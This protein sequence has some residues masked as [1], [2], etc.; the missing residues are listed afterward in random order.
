LRSPHQNSRLHISLAD[1]CT[2]VMLGILTSNKN[3][4]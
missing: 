2:S 1:L 4:S 3:N